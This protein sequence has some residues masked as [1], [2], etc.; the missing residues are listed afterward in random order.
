[1]FGSNFAHVHNPDTHSIT[2][3]L[4]YVS[5]GKMANGSNVYR[6][7]FTLKNKVVY[8]RMLKDLEKYIVKAYGS[9]TE[10]N[11]IR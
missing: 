3:N 1:M 8:F 7:R 4:G 6:L 5:D 11:F 9:G 2:G 10:L